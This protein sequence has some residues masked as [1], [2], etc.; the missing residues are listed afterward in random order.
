MQDY[1]EKPEEEEMIEAERDLAEDAEWKR[2][3]V[4]IKQL[5]H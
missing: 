2:I 5:N 4:G 1:R 3:Q